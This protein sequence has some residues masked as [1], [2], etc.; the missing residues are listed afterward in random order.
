MIIP[1]LLEPGDCIA[2]VSPSYHLDDEQ[3]DAAITAVERMGFRAIPSPHSRDRFLDRYS[4]APELR[5]DDL[6]WAFNDPGIKGV[7]ASRGGYG[8][9]QILDLLG[10]ELLSSHPKWMIG[11]SDITSLHALSL[12]AGV[13]SLHAAMGSFIAKDGADSES[14]DLLRSFLCGGPQKYSWTQAIPGIDG[15]AEGVLVGGNLA[16]LA[17]LAGSAYDPFRFRDIILFIE[18]VEES[19]HNID[20]MLR[21]LA[22]HGALD[23]VRGVVCGA[24]TDCGDE[25]SCG[26]VEALLSRTCFCPGNALSVLPKAIPVAYSFPAGHGGRNVPLVEGCSYVLETRGLDCSL[27]PAGK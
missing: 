16:T 7:L 9:I 3:F 22:L 14:I 13:Q 21:A 8:T 15:R 25:F 1:S 10:P 2:I 17:P 19:A 27:I 12:C 4:A 24:F 18:E 26:S 23:R 5:A 20:R 6:K 11:Y